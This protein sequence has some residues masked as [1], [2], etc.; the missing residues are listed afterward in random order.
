MIEPTFYKTG[1]PVEVRRASPDGEFWQPAT[2]I[3]D[4]GWRIGVAYAD[5]MRQD[6][7]RKH[8]RPAARIEDTLKAGIDPT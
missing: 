1:D 6:I 8:V 5:H 3:A 7:A 2:V 4:Y